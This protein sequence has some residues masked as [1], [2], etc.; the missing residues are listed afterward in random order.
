MK[1]KQI[2]TFIFL[3]LFAA[4]GL[5]AQDIPEIPV[6]VDFGGVNVKFDRSAQKTIEEDIRSLMSNQRFW[7]EKMERAILFF[8]IVEGIL[9]DEEVPIDFKYLAVQESSFKPDVVST[10][11]AVGYW[12]FKAE[13]AIELNLRVD[14]LVDERKNIVSSTHAAAWYLKKNN[15]LFNNWVST[16]YSYYLGA[17]GVKNVIPSNWLNAREVMLTSKTDRYVLRFFAHK[18][19]LEAGIERFRSKSD[20]V[21][22]KSDFGKGLSFREIAQN[23]NVDAAQLAEYNKW[24]VG[25]RVPDDQEY[26]IAVPTKKQQLAEVRSK[27][28]LPPPTTT[29]VV[30]TYEPSGFPIIKKSTV[31]ASGK[32]SHNFYEIN[33]LA[34][35]EA[36]PGDSPKSLAKAGK[37]R[38]S[39]FMKNNDLLRD[40]PI[41]PGNI[42]YLSKKSKR[43]ITPFHTAIPGD[44]WQSISQEYG[45]R[46][47]NLLKYNRTISRNFPIQTG[48]KIWLNK[49]RPRKTSIEIEIPKTITPVKEIIEEVAV[50]KTVEKATVND[51][52]KN[53]SG[54]KKYTPV[55]VE[56]SI[57]TPSTKNSEKEVE[58]AVNT[59]PNEAATYNPGTPTPNASKLS[60]NDRVVII[61]SGDTHENQPE[62]S[63]KENIRKYSDNDD[64]I[65]FESEVTK[66][67][68]ARKEPTNKFTHI[69]LS[70]ET[71]F[72]IAR[73]Y[74][75]PVR[76][77]FALNNR[78]VDTKLL[79][80]QE[81]VVNSKNSGKESAAV[82]QVVTTTISKEVI[83]ADPK[84]T[85]QPKVLNNA[86]HIV[87]RGQT[88]F[89][90]SKLY[91]LSLDEL[92]KLNAL[93][94]KDN[95]EVGQKLLV[96]RMEGNTNPTNA[97][98]SPAKGGAVST[99]TVVSGETLFG[100]S[101]MYNTT[102][103]KIK[104]LNNMTSNVVKLGQ[105]IKIPQ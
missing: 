21:L 32:K 42:Y 100:I 53:S 13:T 66:K 101:Q 5:Y 96:K 57:E 63:S 84:T 95:L 54:R 49:K 78:T 39:S 6:S 15:K 50:T 56:K 35:I 65:G 67:S 80:G 19:A 60:D 28:S 25:D 40:M 98:S 48:Q 31:K 26:F 75:I 92:L 61:S 91:N 52:P 11:K 8:P 7:E 30:S 88:Y 45:I 59:P 76:E 36:K 17:G 44:T 104:A 103:D 22:I 10:S 46:L 102:V 55:L 81:L 33:G 43:A 85:E 24:F 69:V 12:Q 9:M 74:D 4:S 94:V 83:R 1:I 51:I 82:K 47:V 68:N 16:L 70:G 38:Y 20:F 62:S 77:L 90:I 27:L 99:H 64:N 73:K 71:Y 29:A 97:Q 41:I 14:E 2:Y 23:L 105:K 89:G 3:V 87:E 72:S 93:T 18:I 58:I 37:I 79:A 86:F 34:G